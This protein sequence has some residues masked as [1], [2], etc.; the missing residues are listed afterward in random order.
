MNSSHGRM[1][2]YR[3]PRDR[4]K[5]AKHIL[6]VRQSMGQTIVTNQLITVA[7]QTNCHAYQLNDAKLALREVGHS[8]IHAQ[9]ELTH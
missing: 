8:G 5:P 4:K 2:I 7:W 6:K 1:A 3:N 9:T